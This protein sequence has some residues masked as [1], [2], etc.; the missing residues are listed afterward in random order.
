M[1]G[2]QT[3]AVTPFILTQAVGPHQ[4]IFKLTGYNDVL[5]DF[6]VKQNQMTTVA[7]KLVP[8]SGVIPVP[9]GTTVITT[10]PTQTQV[11][12]VPTTSPTQGSGII[13]FPTWFKRWVKIL[14]FGWG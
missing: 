10:V 3:S 4:V 2:G 6:E 8:G 1:D 13:Q 12:T 11:T 7:R 9:T 5:V 14:P